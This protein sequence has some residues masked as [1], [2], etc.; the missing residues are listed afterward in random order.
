MLTY[1]GFTIAQLRILG[2]QKHKSGWGSRYPGHGILTPTL[3]SWQIPRPFEKGKY[4]R[5]IY[6]AK[7]LWFYNYSIE[8]FK[9]SEAQIWVGAMIARPRYLDPTLYS[10][11]IV[12]L[13]TKNVWKRPI[14]KVQ[15]LC[16]IILVLQ[17]HNWGFWDFRSTSLGGGQ[18]TE[19]TVSWP[20]PCIADRLCD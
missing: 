16:Y 9:T 3:Y 11:Q 13:V 7:L 8:D 12:R 6:F 20:P 17:L 2:L 5:N 15:L 10:W 18:D 1:F 4:L 19:N 14:S